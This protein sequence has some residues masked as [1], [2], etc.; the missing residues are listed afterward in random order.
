MLKS[1]KKK[2]KKK[3]NLKKNKKNKKKKMKPTLRIKA[4]NG[5]TEGPCELTTPLSV[6]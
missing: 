3:K 5:K 1:G 2:K 4:G 6:C